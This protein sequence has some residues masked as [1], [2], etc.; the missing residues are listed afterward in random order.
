MGNLWQDRR[1]GDVKNLLGNIGRDFRFA[2][3]SLNKDRRFALTIIV[4]FVLGIGSTTVVFSVVDSL[5]FE[6][7]PYKDYERSTIFQIQDV[8]NPDST[9]DLFSIPE[10]LAFQKQNHAFEDLVGYANDL[11]HEL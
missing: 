5:M 7:L 4:A 6:P 10:F 1:T 8:T 11:R 9:R 2:V 3:R